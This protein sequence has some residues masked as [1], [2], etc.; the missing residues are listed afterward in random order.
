M[1]LKAGLKHTVPSLEPDTHARQHVVLATRQTESNNTLSPSPTILTCKD[2][3][4][5]KFDRDNAGTTSC[6]WL[7]ESK[8]DAPIRI[9]KYCPLPEV[10]YQC[11]VTCDACGEECADDSSFMFELFS[12]P[13][14]YKDC[15]WIQESV[16]TRGEFIVAFLAFLA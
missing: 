11:P 5:Y 16:E 14:T 15:T 7:K 6:A 3:E 2:S 9:N 10:R 8:A 12:I 4:T 1:I 13:G